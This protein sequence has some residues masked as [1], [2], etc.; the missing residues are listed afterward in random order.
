[1][2]YSITDSRV[3][4]IS[5]SMIDAL[6]YYICLLYYNG[7]LLIRDLMFSFIKEYS[8]INYLQKINELNHDIFADHSSNMLIVIIELWIDR[9]LSY[10]FS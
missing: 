7:S 10:E 4:P 6:Y 9:I 1:M 3:E 5:W 2:K 8:F